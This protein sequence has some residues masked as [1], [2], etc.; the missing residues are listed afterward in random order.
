MIAQVFALI[1]IV[2]KAFNLWDAY[3]AHLDQVREAERV[4]R[5]LA[6]SKAV[7]QQANAKSEDEFD[8]AQDI[9]AG[10]KP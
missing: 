2:L 5:D 6:R 9:I 4:E 10:R 3:L 8:Q 7:D 1:Q